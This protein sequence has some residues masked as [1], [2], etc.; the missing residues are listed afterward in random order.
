MNKTIVVFISICLLVF[1]II[2]VG[3]AQNNV[4]PSESVVATVDGSGT[5]L[6]SGSRSSAAATSDGNEPTFPFVTINTENNAEIVSKDDYLT[7]SVSINNCEEEYDLTE[8]PAQIKGRGNSTWDF[9]KKPYKLKFDSKIDLFGN[10]KAKT[11]TLIANYV[12]KSLSRNLLAYNIAT[13]IGLENTTTTQCVHLTLNGD[14]QGVYLVCEQQ[15]VGSTRIDIQDGLDDVDTGYLLELDARAVDEGVEGIDYFTF[16]GQPYGIK[17]PDVEDD[18]W[19]SNFIDYIS[20]YIADCYSAI[21]GNDYELIEQ[22]IDTESFAKC[23]IVHE[24]MHCVDVGYSSFYMYKDAGGKLIC[25]SVWDFDISS[26][27]CDYE[28]DVNDWS[29]MYAKNANRWY[30]KLFAHEEFEELVSEILYDNKTVIQ[31]TID[32][33]VESQL[34]AK[35]DNELN[36]EVWNILN[37]Y[38][39]PNPQAILNLKTWESQLEYLQSWLNSSLDCMLDE[40]FYSNAQ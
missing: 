7:C 11:W 13:A 1:P 36:F 22:L 30:K 17:S 10:G 34:N 25:G 33:V 12:D 15:E 19:N 5:A 8:E 35:Y 28:D 39:W 21:L 16:Y 18:D 9:P 4:N 40:Y 38:V 37:K 14:Y 20:G 2:L 6:P 24:L 27:N 32:E 31:N 26:G 3:C 23:Y 29:V